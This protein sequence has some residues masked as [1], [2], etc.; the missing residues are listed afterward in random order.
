MLGGSA[1]TQPGHVLSVASQFPSRCCLQVEQITRKS[2]L[3]RSSSLG[4]PL[5]LDGPTGQSF[6][7][8]VRH[9]STYHRSM[10]ALW[11]W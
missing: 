8:R 2:E 4:Q 11:L 7:P 5:R 9:G 10:L 6:I 1:A 3:R